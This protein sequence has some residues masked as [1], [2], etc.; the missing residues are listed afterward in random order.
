MDFFFSPDWLNREGPSFAFKIDHILFVVIGLL[1]GVGL[2]FLLHKK[3]K[4]II[5]ITCISI[6]LM[7]KDI[8][9]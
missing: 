4:K 5:K 2:C 3:D 9:R 6:L 1:I 7:I 8:F